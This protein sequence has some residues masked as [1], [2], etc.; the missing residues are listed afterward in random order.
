MQHSPSSPSDRAMNIQVRP[1]R[2]ATDLSRMRQLLV[3]GAQAGISASY[4]HPGSLD[5]DTHCPPDESANQRNFRI[6]EHPGNGDASPVLE[7]FAMFWRHF[8][9]FDLFVS[10]TLYGTPAHEIVMDE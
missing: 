6:W 10:P 7:A 3:T 4:M 8:G 9:T 1:Y 2:D 5:W